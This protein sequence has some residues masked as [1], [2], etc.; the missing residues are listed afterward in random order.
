MR[1][2]LPNM[3]A[4]ARTP[5][6]TDHVDPGHAEEVRPVR[7]GLSRKFGVSGRGDLSAATQASELWL[8]PYAADTGTAIPARRVGLEPLAPCFACIV[9]GWQAP[10]T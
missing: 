8:P 9:L 3:H 10:S 1:G 2:F 4:T 6:C 7:R 5:T